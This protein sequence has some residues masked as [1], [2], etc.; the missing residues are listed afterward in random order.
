[1]PLGMPDCDYATGRHQ[2]EG[3]T[4]SDHS[5]FS[6]E[7]PAAT[8]GDR[9]FWLSVFPPDPEWQPSAYRVTD[10]FGAVLEDWRQ[11]PS[12]FAVQASLSAT[13]VPG[14][15]AVVYRYDV[16]RAKPIHPV[17]FWVAGRLRPPPDVPRS[18]YLYH[19]WSAGEFRSFPSSVHGRQ[20]H[21]VGPHDLAILT[22]DNSG[23]TLTVW[24][25][26]PPRPPWRWS[27]PA[28]V[29]FGVL[30]TAAGVRLR[31]R[32]QSD[33]PTESAKPHQAAEAV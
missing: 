12:E 33:D 14:R 27:V 9:A 18:T 10:T 8:D 22:H 13:P 21:A 32:G 7:R 5:Y 4:P 28:G 26:P 15:P 17:V 11:L 29:A 25:L 3:V 30:L 20:T 24:D 31:R 1:M 2:P 6:R 16:P 23:G 19:D